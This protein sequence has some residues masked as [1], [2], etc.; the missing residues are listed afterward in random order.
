MNKNIYISIL[1]LFFCHFASARTLYVDKSGSDLNSGLSQTDA[2]LTVEKAFL[3]LKSNDI[4][5]IGEGVFTVNKTLEWGNKSISVIGAGAEKTI[6]QASENMIKDISS[7]FSYSVFYNMPSEDCAKTVFESLISDITIRNGAAPISEIMP[8]GV[9][10]GIRN[11]SVLKVKD[12]ILENN[13][14]LNGGA[15]YNEGN[16]TIENTTIRNN[17]AFNYAGGIF[18]TPNATFKETG[19]NTIANNTEDNIF[20]T[21]FVISD[22][23]SGF[24]GKKGTNGNESGAYVENST[25]FS[26]VNNPD[27]SAVNNTSK[28]GKLTRLKSGN[29]WSYAWFEFPLHQVEVVP[30]YLHIMVYKPIASRVCIQLKDRH[31]S[32][33]ANS[34]EI[35]SDAQTTVNG[36]QDLVFEIPKTGG[37]CYIEIKPDFVNQS[38]ASRL[39]ENIDIYFDEIIIDGSP[40]PRASASTE[41]K[42]LGTFDFPK[43]TA[44]LE[45]T[46]VDP[47]I[48]MS[49]L[50]Y[51]SNLIYDYNSTT[52]YFRPYGW[53]TGAKDDSKYLEFTITPNPGINVDVEKVK[54][55]HKPNTNILGPSK[56]LVSYSIGDG[57]FT[58]LPE[59]TFTNRTELVTS[60][61]ESKNL[62]SKAPLKFRMYAYESLHGTEAQKDF[63][64]IDKIE[65]FGKTSIPPTQE[66]QI[67]NNSYPTCMLSDGKLYV[68]GITEKTK[69][70]VYDF[71]GKLIT[72]KYLMSDESI[73]LNNQK[74]VL[75][76]KLKSENN[77][78]VFKIM[79][80]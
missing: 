18:N 74:T 37:Y 56:V 53:P 26:I 64:I 76:I 50:S 69:I 38:P 14:A 48:Q 59:I 30:R 41:E 24:T 13:V 52:G 17:Y 29:W 28:V 57:D 2:F 20:N 15:I 3:H 23:E 7:V 16:L 10:G 46:D 80:L 22:F 27:V 39:A 44:S 32:P 31:A 8:T 5:R 58:D 55:T 75:I 71:M 68:K 12:C 70:T 19:N 34:G 66:K 42:K 33:T 54:I 72:E 21:T 40:T 43:T 67:G 47:N 6:I 45:A 25:Y 73:S 49:A 63:W 65:L 79:N 35:L 36:W 60:S 51:T 62:S 4:I 1:L 9:G 77:E 78:K 11:F 61:V